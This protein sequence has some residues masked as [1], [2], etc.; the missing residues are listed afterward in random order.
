MTVPLSLTAYLAAF[1]LQKAQDK[2][3]YMD[4]GF[5]SEG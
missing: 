5:D 3:S 1:V 4:K 2:L